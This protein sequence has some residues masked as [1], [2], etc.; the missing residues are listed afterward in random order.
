MARINYD[1]WTWSCLAEEPQDIAA[2]EC[3]I[4]AKVRCIPT[5][6][7]HMAGTGTDKMG[8]GMEAVVDWA[9]LNPDWME[10][11]VSLTMKLQRRER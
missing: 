2:A 8:P 4:Q 1:Q 3:R 11:V 7:H 6:I 9:G 10:I 5:Y